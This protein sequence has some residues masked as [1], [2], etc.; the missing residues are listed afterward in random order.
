M[1][2]L[3]IL[4]LGGFFAWRYFA[5]KKREQDIRNWSVDFKDEPKVKFPESKITWRK[6]K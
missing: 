5:K 3:I 1:W 6:D 2:T 4:G